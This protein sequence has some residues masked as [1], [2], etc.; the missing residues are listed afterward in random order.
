MSRRGFI[1]GLT[2]RGDEETGKAIRCDP[3]ENKVAIRKAI[4]Q[5]RGRDGREEKATL[6]NLGIGGRLEEVAG[7]NTWFSAS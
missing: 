6:D 1:H 7:R 4:S 3:V 2:S 5:W